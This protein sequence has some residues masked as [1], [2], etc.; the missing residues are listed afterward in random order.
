MSV[1]FGL[2]IDCSHARPMRQLLGWV[3]VCGSAGHSAMLTIDHGEVKRL[4][5]LVVR[6]LKIFRFSLLEGHSIPALHVQP[7]RLSAHALGGELHCKQSSVSVPI[8]RLHF[9]ILWSLNS[10][11]DC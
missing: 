10:A 2:R 7:S 5:R 8:T 3:P 4:A 1:W 6:P 9:Q 11:L